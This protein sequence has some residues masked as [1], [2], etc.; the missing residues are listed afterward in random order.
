LTIEHIISR[1]Q[2]GHL[3]TIRTSVA[4]R[5]PKL[6][7]DEREA[8]S[9]RIDGMNTVTACSFCNST[10]SHTAA[11]NSL[12][13]LFQTPGPVEVVLRRIELEIQTVLAR[14]REDVAWKLASV[15]AA[16]E[17]DIRPFVEGDGS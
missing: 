11:P 15:K 9:Q 16:F 1:A 12:T 10:T 7:A 14:K 13:S 8:L 5:F 17:R 4:D 3:K 2:G 6:S